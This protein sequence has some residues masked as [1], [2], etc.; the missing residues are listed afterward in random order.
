[1][2]VQAEDLYARSMVLLAQG[3]VAAAERDDIKANE[4]FRTALEL[5]ERQRLAVFDEAEA[6]I[7]WARALRHFGDAASAQVELERAR[8]TFARMGAR[9]LLAEIDEELALLASGAG[10]AGPAANR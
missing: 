5:L 3:S 8:E 4:R 6:R 1:R 9:V 10:T 2:H 7:V